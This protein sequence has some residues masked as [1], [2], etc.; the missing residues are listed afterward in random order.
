MSSRRGPIALLRDRLEYASPF[1][2]VHFDEVRFPDGSTG[3]YSRIVENEGRL[4]VAVLP[5]HEGR[6]GLVRVSRYPVGALL[7]E[8]PR[9]HG[10]SDDPRADAAREL[11]EETGCAADQLTPLGSVHPNSGVLATE[12]ALFAASVEQPD[13]AAAGAEVAEFRWWPVADVLAAVA[14]EAITDAITLSALL[15]AQTLGLLSP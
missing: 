12:V 10:Q 8:I 1:L 13:G 11:A 6:L 9:G 14:S 2:A 7:W 5:L 15:R 3:R 4:G